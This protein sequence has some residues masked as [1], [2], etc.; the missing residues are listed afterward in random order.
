[1]RTE[2]FT[3]CGWDMAGCRFRG[4][5]PF[6]MENDMIERSKKTTGVPLV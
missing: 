6:E 4:N 5:R 2:L 3:R 1:M